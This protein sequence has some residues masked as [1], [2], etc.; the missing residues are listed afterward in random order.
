MA[1]EKYSITVNNSK[2]SADMDNSWHPDEKEIFDKIKNATN[3]KTAYKE[4]YL[5]T[6]F[7]V[8]MADITEDMV[9][10]PHHKINDEDE[11][12]VSKSGVIAAYDRLMAN[13]PNN[14]KALK[15]IN[16]HRK[17]LGIGEFDKSIQQNNTSKKKE[18]NSFK[19]RIIELSSE[20]VTNRR[21]IKW[22]VHRIDIENLNGC[23]FKEPY[24]SN[25]IDS[26]KK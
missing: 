24:V 4:M 3:S 20:Q 9:K 5:I 26:A 10:Y 7:P 6:D 16:K 25:N 1:D 23:N 15:H 2:D 19:G 12:I 13:D 18:V 8:K 17:E 14:E 22:I 11:M 21:N